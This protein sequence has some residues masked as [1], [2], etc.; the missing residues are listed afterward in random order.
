MIFALIT[1]PIGYI[2]SF[3]F[4]W[5]INEF[6]RGLRSLLTLIFYMPTLAGNVYFVWT[7]I[8]SGDSYGLLNSTLIA[9]RFERPDSLDHRIR[10]I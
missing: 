1:G 2:L 8:F 3:I 4:A 9:G 10:S 5:L 6:G 7:Y